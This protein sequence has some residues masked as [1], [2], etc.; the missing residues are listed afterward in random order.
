MFVV[1]ESESPYPEQVGL[2]RENVNPS[3]QANLRTP[4]GGRR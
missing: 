2:R 3:E 1:T 4:P